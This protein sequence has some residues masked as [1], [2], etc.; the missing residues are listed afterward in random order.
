MCGKVLVLMRL[1]DLQL[2]SRLYDTDGHG[3]NVTKVIKLFTHMF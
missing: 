3:N 2:I 1:I